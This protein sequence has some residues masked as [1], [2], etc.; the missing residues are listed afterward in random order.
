MFAVRFPN[1]PGS[2]LVKGAICLFL[3]SVGLKILRDKDGSFARNW[4]HRRS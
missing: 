3:A 1:T 2:I 4:I